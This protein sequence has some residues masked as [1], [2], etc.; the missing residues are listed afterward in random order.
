MLV[1]SLTTATTFDHYMYFFFDFFFGLL[2]L[3][4]GFCSPAPLSSLADLHGAHNI[5][6]QNVSTVRPV[7]VLPHSSNF[8]RF[9]TSIITIPTTTTTISVALALYAL[10]ARFM[11]TLA[12]LSSV[13]M[14]NCAASV[15]TVF[16]LSS[17]W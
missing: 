14:S 8:L 4:V 10:T 6:R 2:G 7:H 15:A 17:C 16:G 12:F 3:V 1:P 11:P 5:K 13:F 9:A